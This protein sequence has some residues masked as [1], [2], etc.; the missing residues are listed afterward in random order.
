MSFLNKYPYSDFHELN[1]DWILARINELGETMKNFI[2]TNTITFSGTWDITE[3]YTAWTVVVDNNIGYLSL[4]P[5]PAGVMLNDT[6]YWAEIFD[7]SAPVDALD[8]RVTAVENE[9]DVITQPMKILCVGDSYG[10]KITENWAH[11]LQQYTGLDSAHFVNKCTGNSGFV[12]N[13]G[14][15]TFQQQMANAPGD[16]STYTHIVI[17]GGFNDA[18]RSDGTQVP[19][20]TLEAAIL[21]AGVYAKQ[22]FVNAKVYIGCPAVATNLNDP[23]TAETMR[24]N[25]SVIRNYYSFTGSQAGFAYM[26]DLDFVIHD[27]DYIDENDIVYNCVFHPNSAGCKMIARAILSYLK[28]GDYHFSN[29]HNLALTAASGITLSATINEN[30]ENDTVVIQNKGLVSVAFAT[31]VADNAGQVT[32]ATAKHNCLF[33]NDDD[34]VSINAKCLF[35]GSMAGDAQII[36]NKNEVK[37]WV[38]AP[39]GYSGTISSIAIGG[40]YKA[41]GIINR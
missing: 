6:D 1:L 41:F 22:N 25:I 8:S 15:Q 28:G 39:Y 9:L 23:A 35:N 7:V 19:G 14:F 16:K 32:I 34:S 36:F 12:G 37:I 38:Q 31:P 33:P 21:A 26:R 11:W 30:I 4:Q 5:V 3:V 27:L 18:Y 2:R 20:N 24:Q 29:Q 40:F 10:I 17:I 13:A